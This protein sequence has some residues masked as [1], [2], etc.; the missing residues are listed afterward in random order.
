MKKEKRKLYLFDHRI[1]WRNF[2]K[3]MDSISDSG[4][5]PIHGDKILW[6]MVKKRIIY[7]LIDPK[8]KYP[9]DPSIITTELPK[10][11]DIY[12]IKN[13]LSKK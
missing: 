12:I 11:T 10:N 1:L 9:K 7:I 13:R 6:E 5:V 2:K 8:V 4:P 3:I